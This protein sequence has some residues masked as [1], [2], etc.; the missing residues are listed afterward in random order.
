KLPQ[1]YALQHPQDWMDSLAGA[2]QTA[3]GDAT[4]SP[5]SIVGIGV[6]FTSCTMLP[7]LADG[8]PLCLLDRY[9]HEPLGWPTLWKHHGA[10]AETDRMNEIARQRKEP[11]L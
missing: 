6:D 5:E 10:K 8:T 11:W 4:L 1:D 2:C 7:T 9:K 3:M